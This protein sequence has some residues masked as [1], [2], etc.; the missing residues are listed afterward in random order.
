MLRVYAVHGVVLCIRDS[1]GR[2]AGADKY[3]Q[4][5]RIGGQQNRA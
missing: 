3:H 1:M 4:S 5:Y 2:W